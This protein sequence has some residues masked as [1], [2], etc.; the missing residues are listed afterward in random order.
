MTPQ[1][2]SDHGFALYFV[3]IIV[4]EPVGGTI[5]RIKQEFAEK[6]DCKKPLNSPAHITL[7][8]PF[9]FRDDDI[10]TIVKHLKEFS[11]TRQ[12]IDVTLSG[13]NAFPPK[14][15]FV[16]VAPNEPLQQLYVAMQ[17][18]VHSNLAFLKKYLYIKLTPHVTVGYRDLTKSNFLKAWEFFQNRKFEKTFEADKLVLLRHNKKYWETFCEFPFGSQ[19]TA[20]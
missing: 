9:Y 13:F 15:I 18:Y 16:D 14:A 3:I 8:Q 11:L 4:P 17:K 2:I 1:Q 19:L 5:M 6:Y 20:L 10:E 7:I 12:K